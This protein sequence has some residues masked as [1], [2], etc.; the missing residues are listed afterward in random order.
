[1]KRS[2]AWLG[3]ALAAVLVTTSTAV[4]VIQARTAK[5]H[6][7][8]S[9]WAWAD[10]QLCAQDYQKA[11]PNVTINYST[12]TNT[13][14]KLNVLKRAGGSG[15]PDVI[16]DNSEDI[17]NLYQLGYTTDLRSAITPAILAKYAPGT[18][19][20]E[21]INGEVLAFPHD[22]AAFGIWYNVANM[23]AAGLTVPTSYAQIF[24]DAATLAKTG[25]YQISWNGA[26]GVALEELAWANHANWYVHNADGSWSVN[27]DTPLTESLATEYVKAVQSKGVLPDDPFGPVSG[28]AYAAGKVA[29]AFSANWLGTY[30]IE[31]G[32]PKQKGEWDFAASIPS[33]G[34]WGGAMFLVPPQ[35]KY[36][37]E[38][39][40]LALYCST[41]P[42]FQSQVGTVP[43][44]TGV[45]NVA[46]AFK[47][48]PYFAH[49]A[50]TAAQ[51]KLSAQNTATGWTYGP[52]FTYMDTQTGAALT[53]MFNGMPV[54]Q[55]LQQ[56]Q[57]QVASNL[58][59]IGVKVK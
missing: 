52:N 38:A 24:A 14:A 37:A 36:H 17:A 57:S 45:Y 43:S 8:L 10:R 56:L 29:F 4:P 19:S 3:A 41:S 16:F 25:K 2:Q 39:A 13:I 59:L 50:V 18:I 46:G 30:G 54:H 48:N 7:T 12:V 11:N 53:A 34:W 28:K 6:I 27:I 21:E 9:M 1:M 55:A 51:L 26:D 42:T 5:A 22:M 32:Y 31:P 33:V 40:K 35:S 15:I 49:P 47:L 20:Q 58:R 44:F 23:K